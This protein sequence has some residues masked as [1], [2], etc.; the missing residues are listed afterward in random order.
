MDFPYIP[1]PHVRRRFLANN[2]LYAPTYLFLKE[3]QTQKPLPYHTKSAP[4]RMTG[5]G[6]AK[7]DL[8]FDKEREWLLLK[9]QGDVALEDKIMD[10]TD[11][12]G[13]E[14]CDDGI[15]CGC[16]FSSNPFVSRCII[17]GLSR[18]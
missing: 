8:E 7:Q 13:H 15:E 3:E 17:G 4:S 11:E 14:N 9:M 16:C 2:G 10:E 18:D 12:Q 5:K 6:K 1:K